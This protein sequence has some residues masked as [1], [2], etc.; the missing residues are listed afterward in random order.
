MDGD[1][2]Y[3][4][5]SWLEQTDGG[6]GDSGLRDTGVHIRSR[7]L[8]DGA[9]S[10][11]VRLGGRGDG[12]VAL[13]VR[14]GVVHA[15]VGTPAGVMQYVA[16]GGQGP[17]GPV[18]LPD[19]GS[20]S[21]RVGDDGRARI[22]YSTGPTLYYA[23]V[24][25]DGLHEVKVASSDQTNLMSPSLMLGPGIGRTWPGPRTGMLAVDAPTQDRA[26]STGP[27][28]LT[29]STETGRRTGSVRASARQRW[30]SIPIPG[31]SIS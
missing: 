5:T 28:S 7:T 29:G 17:T 3:L 11:P 22:A 20:A 9:W 30:P 23:R 26:R 8:P 10:E 31:S 15:L 18:N 14:D 27:S 12:L 21:L 13:R 16:T 19:A 25:T 6:C 2:M 24:D 1:T 4:G